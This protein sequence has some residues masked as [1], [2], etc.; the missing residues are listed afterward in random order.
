MQ[1]HRS[2]L[3]GNVLRSGAEAAEATHIYQKSVIN[4]FREVQTT[5][6]NLENLRSIYTLN[7]EEA[8]VLSG[9]VDVSNELFKVG[10]ASYLEVITAQRNAIE[11]SLIAIETKKS[12]YQSLITL[13]RATGGGW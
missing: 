6:T 5:I 12:M 2:A 7:L 10:Y 9:A 4:A 8:T 3:K 13:Y 11:A 1:Q